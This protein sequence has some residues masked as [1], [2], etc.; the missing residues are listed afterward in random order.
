MINAEKKEPQHRYSICKHKHNLSHRFVAGGRCPASPEVDAR[1]RASRRASFV[2]LHAQDDT[3]SLGVLCDKCHIK[4]RCF[5]PR[6][7]VDGHVGRGCTQMRKVCFQQTVVRFQRMQT[8]KFYVVFQNF[9][10]LGARVP[11]QSIP[12][13]YR[14]PNRDFRVWWTKPRKKRRNFGLGTKKK[15]PRFQIDLGGGEFP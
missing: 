12:M 10:A 15:S 11:I 3:E 1:R 13:L 5:W 6:T 14:H 2:S 4:N 9:R 7:Y 8:G